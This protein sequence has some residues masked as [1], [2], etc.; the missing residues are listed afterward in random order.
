MKGN[1]MK[2]LVDRCLAVED[3][4]C[5]GK[6]EGGQVLCPKH[7]KLKNEG[8]NF[9]IAIVPLEQFNEVLQ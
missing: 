9:Y 8:A 2:P 4:R 7:L 3:S 5:D 1:P 6:P